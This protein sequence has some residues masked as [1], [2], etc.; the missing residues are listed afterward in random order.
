M[1]VLNGKGKAVKAVAGGVTAAFLVSVILLLVL[2][3]IMLKLQPDSG[4]MEIL[5]MAVYL[6]GCLVGGWY[7]G[8]KGSRR[9]FLWGL[10]VG[11][12]Y[13]LLL[14]AVSGMSERAG[15]LQF[16]SSLLVLTLCLI[17]AMIGGMLA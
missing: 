12:V 1:D 4:V 9:K 10:V 17:G 11:L 5:I 8:R 14:F 7:G 6:L 2:A 16:G 15:Q 13:F 3:F